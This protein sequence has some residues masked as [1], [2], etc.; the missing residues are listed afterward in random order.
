M[1]ATKH[2]AHYAVP[3][4][5]APEKAL[6]PERTLLSSPWARGRS[7][8]LSREA[9]RAVSLANADEKL[10]RD[11]N[12]ARLVERLESAM[13]ALGQRKVST[14]AIAEGLGIV[15][16]FA[17]RSIGH[18]PFDEQLFAAFV[19][20]RGG[21]AEMATGEGKTLTA[22]IAGA[23]TAVS[24]CPVHVLSSND[25]LVSRDAEAMT[26]F[27]E[28]LGL[29]V[30]CV[31]EDEAD[32][33]RRSA[34]YRC[35]VTYLTPREL[36][37]DYLRD[38]RL[39]SRAGPLG[40]R[41]TRIGRRLGSG[42]RQRGLH[43]AI[44]DEADDVLIDQ[45]RTP[46]VLSEHASGADP[47]VRARAALG[48]ADGCVEL[49][50]YV[51]EKPGSAPRLTEAGIA[52][53]A[54]IGSRTGFWS[55]PSE[56]RT[57]VETALLA[58][59]G[60]ERDVDY[61][62]REG[63]VEIVDAP[64]GRRSPRQ[65]FERGLHQLLEA[66]E[67]LSV[68][69]LSEASAR[70]AGQALF[71]R[72]KRLSAM[73]GTAAEARGELWRVYGLPVVHVPLRRPLRREVARL[74]CHLDEASKSEAILRRVVEMNAAGRPVLVATDSVEAS[75]LMAS[76]L[77]ERGIDTQLLNAAD[78]AVEAGI[79]ADAGLAGRVTVT[80]NM[81]GRGTDIVL[82]RGVADDGG[83][84]VI[85]ARVGESRRV[86]RQLFGRC[87]RQGDP[88]S[89]ITILS[90][91]DPVFKADLPTSLLRWAKGRT[92]K[93]GT[94]APG[95]AQIILWG[96]QMAEERRADAARRALLAHQRGRDELLAFAGLPE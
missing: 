17:A 68:S 96:V 2:A 38:H 21:L 4:G 9:A 22:A 20:L 84:H 91:E 86:D 85:C 36:A 10:L 64:T 35:D 80:T 87:G 61:V 18:R 50:D 40:R 69:G 65:N 1:S 32:Q 26:P 49:R 47:T 12:D 95:I 23:I 48:I 44:V 82:G 71:R 88:G 25:Y 29:R 72:Y 37:F 41:V 31:V 78:D 11:L 76:A 66:K 14:L 7:F 58:V 70:V 42:L 43:F 74:E 8:L 94:L 52:R 27:Y 5:I 60:L 28:R 24:G 63:A 93:C 46:F 79:I 89:F 15:R 53:V 83:L 30:G 77:S 16:E 39:L 34:A 51:Q 55:H 90:L 13:P 6:I 73:T 56:C 54:S 59:H 3:C 45:A 62:I 33:V 67:G 57:W 19:L 81:A 75:R 92:G